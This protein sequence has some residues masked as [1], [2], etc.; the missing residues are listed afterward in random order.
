MKVSDVISV[1]DKYFPLSKALPW[2][3]TGL[4]IG[5]PDKFVSKV[6]I[7]LDI[8]RK[9]A[10]EAASFKADLIITHHPF[11]MKEIKQL[12]PESDLGWVLS[13]LLKKNI[14]LVSFHTNVDVSPGG[15]AE[16]LG[17]LLGLTDMKP[18]TEEG[19]GRVGFLSDPVDSRT[20]VKYVKKAL[21][22]NIPLRVTPARKKIS[23]VA[24][25]PGSGGD[26]ID[27]VIELKADCYVTGDIKYHQAYRAKGIMTL[28]D[29]GHY[30]T[31]Y[32]FC[33]LI[34]SI[35]KRETYLEVKISESQGNPFQCM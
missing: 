31:E 21:E 25:C 29:A 28:I 5:S 1:V 20:F 35:L 18:I 32:P 13:Y 14:A 19:I 23:K 33:L 17:N 10:K 30:H 34:A 2:D 12:N 4:Q 24:V 9:V 7:S 15:L 11:F 26:L 6:L 27:K 8:D 3:N 22:I 16:Y